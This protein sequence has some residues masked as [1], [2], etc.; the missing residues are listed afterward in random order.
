M[1]DPYDVLGVSRTATSGEIRYAYRRLAKKYHPDVSDTGSHE[2]FVELNNAFELISDAAQRREYDARNPARTETDTQPGEKYQKLDDL[3]Q[4]YYTASHSE[5]V[6][7]ELGRD[8]D[9]FATTINSMVDRGDMTKSES[10]AYAD[11]FAL[12]AASISDRVVGEV[13]DMFYQDPEIL[14]KGFNNAEKAVGIKSWAESAASNVIAKIETLDLSPQMRDKVDTKKGYYQ[15]LI[16]I[17][18][19][20][21]ASDDGACYIATHVYG[22]YSHPNVIVLRAFRDKY[23]AKKSCRKSDY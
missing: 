6:L 1:R 21:I 3:I 19:K 22:S 11:M 18:D 20:E 16:E 5:V 17:A 23:L 12:L 15:E 13:I 14:E 8:I 9:A 7:E 4:K 10:R 2:A